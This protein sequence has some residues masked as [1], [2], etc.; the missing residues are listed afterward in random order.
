[1]LIHTTKGSGLTVAAA[2]DH[3]VDGPPDTQTAIRSE[4][5]LARLTIT[6]TAAPGRPLRLTKFVGTSWSGERTVPAL[7]DQVDAALAG[8]VQTG[9]E[10]LLQ[11]QRAFLDTFWT[12]ADIEIDGDAE[13]QQAVRFALFHTVQA[14][15]R[16]EQRLTPAKG[17]TGPRCGRRTL[18]G[19]PAG[20]VPPLLVTHSRRPPL[21]GGL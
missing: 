11:Q 13:L 2:M 10:G 21:A 3:R 16:G 8:A 14:G 17:L 9:W 6:A 15:A 5:D 7:R 20:A 12:D 19:T 4:G 1:M 18:P